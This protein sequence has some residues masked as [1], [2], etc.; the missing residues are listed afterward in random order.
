M[1]KILCI[2]APRTEMDAPFFPDL[3][4]IKVARTLKMQKFFVSLIDLD[5][6]KEKI[7]SIDDSIEI[8]KPEYVI[9]SADTNSIQEAFQLAELVKHKNKAAKNIFIGKH[10]KAMPSETMLACEFIDFVVPFFE[11]ELVSKIVKDFDSMIINGIYFR[12]KNEVKRTS[13]VFE[14]KDFDVFDYFGRDLVQLP[15]YK[16]FEVGKHFPVANLQAGFGCLFDCSWCRHQNFLEKHRQRKPEKVVQEIKELISLGV[17]EIYF[18]DPTFTLD[19]EWVYKLCRLIS[20]E[21]INVSWQCRARADT[22]DKKLLEAMKK[23]GCWLIRFGFES[24]SQ[25]VL[26]SFNKISLV[27]QNLFA[28]Q[29]AKEAGIKVFGYFLLGAVNETE[30]SI[31]ETIELAKKIEP[32][33]F[34][35]DIIRPSPG[36]TLFRKHEKE[37]KEMNVEW[38]EYFSTDDPLKILKIGSMAPEEL[39]E[40][41]QTAYNEMHSSLTYKMKKL[42]GRAPRRPKLD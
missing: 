39:L 41:K 12:D 19:K 17:K 28:A 24:G 20:S 3:D 25:R 8:M 34:V 23:A 40:W 11:E 32:D 35:F 31:W 9:I 18:T 33:Y 1:K 27:E 38:S 30:K 2:N 15:K 29:I 37:F 5:L 14:A 22:V 36:T 4:L 42:F 10:A 26:D 6:E 13:P 16:R 21:K 7:D